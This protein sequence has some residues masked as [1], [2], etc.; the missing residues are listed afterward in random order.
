[1]KY[2]DAIGKAEDLEKFI[3]GYPNSSIDSQLEALTKSQDSYREEI[4]KINNQSIINPY[5]L[6]GNVNADIKLSG[7][8]LSDLNLEA[9]AFGKVWTNKL[10]I[11]NSKDIRPFKATF[12]GNLASGYGRFSLLNFNFSLLSLFA[13]IPS[14]IDG[15]FGLNGK[16]SLANG[17]PKVTADLNY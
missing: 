11:I 10:N 16:Y 13:P 6:N 15:Y 12:N 9:K 14:A 8:N 1:M 17:T 7:P 3:I 2:S 4:A 5:D